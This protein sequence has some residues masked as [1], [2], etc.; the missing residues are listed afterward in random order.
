MSLLSLLAPPGLRRVAALCAVLAAWP[1]AAQVSASGQPQS[2][3]LLSL[4]ASATV[5]VPRD[6]LELV[7]ST[8]REAPDASTVQ[9]Q[10]MQALEPALAEARKLARPGQV[11]VSTGNFAV[12]PRYAPKGGVTQWQG[13]VELRVEGRDIDALTRLVPRITTLS[14]ARV[15]Y[16]LSRE[17]REK[18][19]S[20]VSGRAIAR[21]RSQAE[22]YAKAFGF[23][24]ITLR[25]VEVQSQD[26]AHPPVPVMRAA[27]AGA[28]M[29]ADEA[30]PV[31]A[32]KASVSI[33]VSGTVQMRP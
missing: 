4:S 24:A 17:A 19:Q 29:L 22:A 26:S 7:F 27:R 9:T 20:E 14:V 10:L 11:E 8:Q 32:G 2:E 5:D 12:Y 18:V 28:A 30:M 3:N 13:S 15:G 21:F 16:S 33:T 23:S 1:C 31:E 6:V 25:N